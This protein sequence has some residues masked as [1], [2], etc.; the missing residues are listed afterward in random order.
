M[1]GGAPRVGPAPTS[2]AARLAWRE[3]RV[4]G[5]GEGG[6]VGQTAPGGPRTSPGHSCFLGYLIVYADVGPG[7]PH[8]PHTKATPI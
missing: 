3:P 1:C 4:E 7:R 8:A 2:A 6:C 5:P